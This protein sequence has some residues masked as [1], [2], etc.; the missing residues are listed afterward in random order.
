MSSRYAVRP[1]TFADVEAVAVLQ[2]ESE[3]KVRS[4]AG[5]R[6]LFR[7][8]PVL[9][10]RDPASP[11]GWVLEREGAVHGYLGSVAV[12]YVLDGRPLRAAASTGYFVREAVHPEAVR[13]MRTFLRQPHLDLFVTTTACEA[14]AAVYRL[15][16]AAVPR[17]AS[18]GEGLVWIAKDRVVLEEA[19]AGAGASSAAAQLLAA[20]GA[21]VVRSARYVSG[22]ATA[23]RSRA[24]LEMMLLAP[25][26]FDA[27]FDWLCAQLAQ[28]KG[29][30]VRRNPELLRWYF[31]DPDGAHAPVIFAAMKGDR[32]VAYAAGALHRPPSPPIT[33]LRLLDLVAAP[34]EDDALVPLI[35]SA[36]DHAQTAEAGLVYCPPCGARLA[37]Q[38]Q[39]LRPY[40]RRR[41]FP[42]HFLRTAAGIDAERLADPGVWH[43]T[44]L[45]GDS[46][47]CL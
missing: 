42:V 15:F 27:R 24:K 22:I 34:G 30:R 26:D 17:D 2:R 23:P 25:S 1:A 12:D 11:S 35:H 46:P 18:F 21:P 6:W 45:D 36:L 5:W 4:E 37:S 14:D 44:G 33:H 43:A 19:L 32:V 16:K 20:A 3:A 8:N 13:L 39:A 38:L 41:D 47:F 29:L 40:V 28:A 9:R 10:H 31:S 7:D